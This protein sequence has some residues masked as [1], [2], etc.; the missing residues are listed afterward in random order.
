MAEDNLTEIMKDW[1]TTDI[2]ELGSSLLARKTSMDK[3]AAK[4]AKRADRTAKIM[5]GV[6]GMQALYIM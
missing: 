6:M 1:D 2:G 5:A 4:R 3:A